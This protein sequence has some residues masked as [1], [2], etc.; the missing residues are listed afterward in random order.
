MTMRRSILLAVLVA[1]LQIAFLG[2]MIAGRASVLRKGAEVLLKVEPVDPR[3]LLRGDYVR[4]GYEIASI[5]TDLVANLPAGQATS[6]AGQIFVRIGKDGDGYW[7]V[8]S[9]TLG[10]PGDAPVGEGELVIRGTAAA[11][12]GL[13]SGSRLSVTYGIER[14]YLPEGEGLQME[15][16]MRV[17]SFGVLVALASDG[18]PQIK[19]LMDG[20]APV[21]EEPPY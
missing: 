2:W 7:R 6:E 1:L 15:K 20:A 3:D 16:D 11:A 5:P 8:R 18:A 10:V 14:Y 13:D 9:A 4:L 12:W 17:R 19:A 21:Y